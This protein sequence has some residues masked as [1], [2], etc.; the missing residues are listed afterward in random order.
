M[1]LAIGVEVGTPYRMI[2]TAGWVILLCLALVAEFLPVNISRDGLRITF[3]L[4]FVAGMAVALGAS[5]ALLVDIAVTLASAFYLALNGNKP[6]RF[7]VLLNLSV[8]LISASLGGVAYVLVNDIGSGHSTL[9]AL[10]FTVVYA[11]ANFFLVCLAESTLTQNR[12]TERLHSTL[13]VGAQGMVLY[14]LA[15]LAVS[16]L[17]IKGLYWLLPPM[18]LP[19]IVLRKV[20]KLKSQLMEQYYETVTSLTLMLQ[21]AHPYTHGHL[22]RVSRVSEEVAIHLGLSGHRARLVREASVLHDIGKIAVDEAILDK[23]AKLTAEEYAHVKRHSAL[24]AQIIAPVEPLRALVPWIK[25]HH[26]RPDGS[27]YPDGLSDIE[28]PIESKI[29]AVVDAY[30]AMTGGDLPS[31]RRPY[32]EPMTVDQALAELDRCSGTQ[33]DAKVV[34]AFRHVLDRGVV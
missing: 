16:I 30:D 24:G 7:W 29:I 12:L 31:D 1:L 10:A 8:A 28:I 2:D 15:S 19:L 26:E 27:G 33:F 20:L 6:R 17:V 14:C 4:P 3:S 11:A 32:R 13:A 34:Q 21:R 23:P 5:G 18:L 22:E 25:H 9:A